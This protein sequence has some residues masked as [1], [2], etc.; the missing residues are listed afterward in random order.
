MGRARSTYRE[1][2][3]V[4]RV[5]VGKP[6]GKRPLGRLRHGWDNKMDL[7]EVGSTWLTI[8]AGSR[9]LWVPVTT[10]WRVLRLRIEERPPT[11]RVA[12]NKLNKQSRTADKGWSSSLGVGRGANNPSLLKPMFSNTHMRDDSSGHKTIRR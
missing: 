9:H 11:R 6:V 4:Y 1:R 12:A 2:K 7:H 10:A 8:G 3:G 5:L